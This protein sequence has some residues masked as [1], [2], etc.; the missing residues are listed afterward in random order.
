MPPSTHQGSDF[1][2][3]AEDFDFFLSGDFIFSGDADE[4]DDDDDDIF[5]VLFLTRL[6]VIRLCVGTLFS[7]SI[8]L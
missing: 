2:T 3:E 1:A 5:I 8:L 6:L 7:L 4:D